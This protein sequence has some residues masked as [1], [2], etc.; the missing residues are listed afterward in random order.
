MFPQGVFVRTQ[1]TGWM[2]ERLMIEWVRTVWANRPGDLM[3]R[4]SLLVLGAFR[5]HR[6]QSIK[7]A[8]KEENTDLAII[9][10]GMTRF[11]PATGCRS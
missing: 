2:D 7:T 11:T 10:G 3:K 4:R 6:M 8:F 5:C 1:E 9:L